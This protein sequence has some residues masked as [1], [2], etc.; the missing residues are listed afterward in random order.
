[1]SG[2]GGQPPGWQDPYG[3]SGYQGGGPQGWQDPYGQQGQGYGPPGV[4][5]GSSG[6][7]STIGALICNILLTVLCCNLLAIPGIVTSTIAINRVQTNPDS[8][9][10]LTAWSWVLF[11]ANIVIMIT[12]VTVGILLGWFDSDSSSDF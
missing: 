12:F 8:A 10:T 5:Y 11:A 6:N 2:Y 9:R 3:Q 7:G 1:M 4:P